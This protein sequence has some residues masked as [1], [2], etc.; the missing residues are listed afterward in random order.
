[1]ANLLCNLLAVLT[2][3]RAETAVERSIIISVVGLVII[4]LIPAFGHH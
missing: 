3:R 1:M 4:S 2:D